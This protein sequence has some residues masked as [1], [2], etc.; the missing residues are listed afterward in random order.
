MLLNPASPDLPRGGSLPLAT[1]WLTTGYP[2]GGLEVAKY[3]LI[4]GA[5]ALFDHLLEN[6]MVKHGL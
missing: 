1:L 5:L 6:E 3:H 2:M 4:W